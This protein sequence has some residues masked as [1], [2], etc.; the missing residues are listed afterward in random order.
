MTVYIIP[1]CMYMHGV[2][3]LSLC[4]GTDERAIINVLAHR[5]NE[6]RQ[7]IKLKFKALYGKVIPNHNYMYFTSYIYNIMELKNSVY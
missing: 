6:Q 4:A 3:W 5:S 2:R 1:S 7:E